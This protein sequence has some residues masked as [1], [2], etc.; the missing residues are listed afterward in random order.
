LLILSLLALNACRRPEPLPSFTSVP[1][2]SLTAQ[3]GRQVTRDDFAGRVWIANFV[4]TD[5]PGPCPMLTSHM[6]DVQNLL[7]ERSLDV[8]LVSFSVDPETDTPEVLTRYGKTFGADFSRWTFLTGDKQEIYELI[9]HGFLLAVS[10]GAVSAEY[11]AGPGVITHSTRFALV[12][13]QGE[14][15]GYYHGEE[16]A[17]AAEIV[18]GAERL[19]A[20]SR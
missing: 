10:D 14:V 17:V 9:L 13:Q 18:A 16:P 7:Q 6:R 19:L 12:D 8:P 1:P 15:R 2:F 4:F 20:E 3:D 5:C 11:S